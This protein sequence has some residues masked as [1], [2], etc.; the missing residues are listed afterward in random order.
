MKPDFLLRFLF[1][2]RH[3]FIDNLV[4]RRDVP[5]VLSKYFT[6]FFYLLRKFFMLIMQIH[7][8]ISV[9]LFFDLINF[10]N[11]FAII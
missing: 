9:E 6:M 3:Q 2:R 8:F 7:I 4:N 5:A 10:Y 1:R 11:Q